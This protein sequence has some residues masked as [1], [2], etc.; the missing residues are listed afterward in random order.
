MIAKEKFQNVKKKS[1]KNM[2]KSQKFDALKSENGHKTQ[3][4]REFK[5]LKKIV[6]QNV[7][8]KVFTNF[9]DPRTFGCGDMTAEKYLLSHKKNPKH[10][11]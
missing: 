7:M 8:R 5:I 10:H 3:K 6:M 4:K 2:T 1:K 11:S 9:H